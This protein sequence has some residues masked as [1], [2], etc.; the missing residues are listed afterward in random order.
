MSALWAVEPGVLAHKF[1]LR[2]ELRL[3]TNP[4]VFE[5]KLG[6]YGIGM[7]NIKIDYPEVMQHLYGGT[8]F[9]NSWLFGGLVQIVWNKT[10]PT[11]SKDKW[12]FPP[13]RY[14]PRP[15]SF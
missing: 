7:G 3:R 12:G 15:F 10:S 14:I 6:V 9:Y 2:Q 4:I 13:G 11:W 1:D 5:R 8:S